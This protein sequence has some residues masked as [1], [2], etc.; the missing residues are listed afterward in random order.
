[1]EGVVDLLWA[2]LLAPG[3]WQSIAFVRVEGHLPFFFPLLQLSE[4]FLQSC[5]IL[6]TDDE[7]V[8]DGVVREKSRRGRDSVW[9]VVDVFHPLPTSAFGEPRSATDDLK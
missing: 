3:D 5:K 8:Q 2:G 7:A 9:L 6:S 1:M 4:V